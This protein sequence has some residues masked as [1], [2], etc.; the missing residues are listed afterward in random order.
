M[1]R[2]GSKDPTASPPPATTPPAQVIEELRSAIADLKDEVETA[3]QAKRYAYENLKKQLEVNDATQKAL[4]TTRKELM[5]TLA[6]QSAEVP[7]MTAPTPRGSTQLR[8][9]LGGGEVQ[10]MSTMEAEGLIKQLYERVNELEST[11]GDG[12]KLV[13]GLKSE[14]ASLKS[15]NASGMAKLKEMLAEKARLAQQVQRAEEMEADYEGKVTMVTQLKRELAARD[16]E[17]ERMVRVTEKMKEDHQSEKDSV[18][19]ASVGGEEV[20]E[21]RQQ[22]TQL[23]GQLA[24]EK[25]VSAQIGS[26]ESELSRQVEMV[27]ELENQ[28]AEKDERIE[29]LEG[30]DDRIKEMEAELAKV[31]AEATERM[32]RRSESETAREAERAQLVKRVEDYETQIVELVQQVADLKTAQAAAAAAREDVSSVPERVVSSPGRSPSR[33]AVNSR[34]DE[35]SS[36]SS[37]NGATDETVARLEAIRGQLSEKISAAASAVQKAVEATQTAKNETQFWKKKYLEDVRSLTRRMVLITDNG[38]PVSPPPVSSSVKQFLGKSPAR[39][40][41]PTRTE[42]LTDLL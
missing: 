40:P 12:A 4:E 19:K 1:F 28:V 22:I 16:A 35:E 24:I 30:A 20:E 21:L 23:E 41:E 32:G 36:D 17:L 2:R 5:D 10:V 13:D 11:G 42:D 8:I 27:A 6:R 3:T 29:A 7:V 25:E 37:A 31:K 33:P 18:E 39:L 38:R 34:S 14:I 26:I 15:I 9:E